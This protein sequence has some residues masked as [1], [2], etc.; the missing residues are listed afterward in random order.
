MGRDAGI[1][2]GGWAPA[3]YRTEIGDQ[4]ELLKGFGLKEMTS[5]HYNGRTTQNI[6]DSDVTF[7]F[8]DRVDSGGTK[9]TIDTCKKLDKN[10]VI[11]PDAE[12]IKEY[13]SVYKP[14]VVN[15]AGNRESVAPGIQKR[16]RE[17]IKEA[18]K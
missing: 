4:E 1:E 2:T 9:L 8:A 6:K 17:I 15:I 5:S 18:L 13:I 7:I 14:E 3:G 10:C 16:V 12:D 11:N